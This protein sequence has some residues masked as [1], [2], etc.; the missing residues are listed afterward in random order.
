[1]TLGPW[2]QNPGSRIGTLLQPPLNTQQ[3]SG[4]RE[5]CQNPKSFSHHQ[6]PEENLE[7]GEVA[8]HLWALSKSEVSVCLGEPN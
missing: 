6:E 2:D 3:A 5:C 1:M 4:P 7:G 8:S